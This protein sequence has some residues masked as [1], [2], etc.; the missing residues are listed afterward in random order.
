VYVRH[1]DH[2][3]VQTHKST[4]QKKTVT[5]TPVADAGPAPGTIA[6]I[7]QVT[8]YTAAQVTSLAK[9]DYGTSVPNSNYGVTQ[10]LFTYNSRDTANQPIIIYG[11]AY[12][13]TTPSPAPIF[14]MAPG[15]TGIGDECAAS[16]ENIKVSNW[17]NYES[18]MMAYASQGYAGVI[19]DYEGMRDPT[20]IHHYMVG[21]LEGRAVLDSIRAL[22][23]LPQATGHLDTSHIFAAGYSQGGHSAFWADTINSSYAPDVKLSGIVTWAPVLNVEETWQD[24]ESGSDVDWFGPYVLV[25]YSDYYKTNYNIDNIL[26]PQFSAHLEQNVLANCIGTDQAFWGTNPA[27]VYQ[28]Q[29]LADLK[30][31]TL[32]TSLYGS[33]EKDLQENTVGTEPT[34]TPKLIE[35]GESDDV[36][37]ASQAKNALPAMCAASKGPVELNLYPGNTHYTIMHESFTDTLSWMSSIISKSASSPTTPSAPTCTTVVK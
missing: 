4:T 7:I 21:P 5:T 31:G 2:R 28:P 22:E 36:V 17:G 3:V 14:A 19:T 16:L 35:Q 12:I 27:K 26:L 8:H 33:L 11:R 34:T 10:V 37:L 1:E 25:S 15:T 9:E 32:P 29:F 20:R 30:T 23:K 18:V 24:I 6:Q 13:P